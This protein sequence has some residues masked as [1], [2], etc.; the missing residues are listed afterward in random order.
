MSQRKE[1]KGGSDNDDSVSQNLQRKVPGKNNSFMF[2]TW[3]WKM[4]KKQDDRQTLQSKQ[5]KIN[6][7]SPSTA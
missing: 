5:I 1:A 3:D 4:G 7:S 6:L 2:F